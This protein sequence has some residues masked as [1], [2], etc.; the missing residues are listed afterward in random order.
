M[1]R[2]TREEFETIA[3]KVTERMRE[4]SYP[5]IASIS[6][7]VERNVGDHV[8]TGLYL[9]IRND[10][11]LLTNEHVARAIR[12]TPLAH[13]LLEGE[14][15]TRVMNPFQVARHPYDMA[16]TR[17]ESAAWSVE[18]NI[19]RAL[20]VSHVGSRHA[21]EDCDFLFMLGYS[22]QRSYFSPTF[23]T[24]TNKG[25]PYLTQE[26]K[27]SPD[28]LSE[29]C[30]AIPYRPELARSL[31]PKGANLPDPHGFS[32]SPVWNTNF[33]RC[34]LS[35]RRWTPE[36]SR[37][38]GIIIRWSEA[39]GHLIAVR[40]EFIAEFLLYALRCEA[41]YFNW[42]ARG[43]PENDALTDWSWAEVSIPDFATVQSETLLNEGFS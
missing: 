30:F 43:R 35:G 7:E 13:Q 33:R 25:T 41:A 27:D 38:T 19:R 5:Y 3:L 40:V 18:K 14:G 23:E 10:S 36:E 31:D 16:L 26:A 39:T 21:P 6:R 1:I 32:G 8:G 15:A 12:E 29:M 24:L 37:V 2:P 17:I 22:G 9:R 20:N 34:M 28:D 4:Y 11:Y 42:I